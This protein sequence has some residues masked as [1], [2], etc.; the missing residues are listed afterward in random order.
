MAARRAKRRSAVAGASAR[1]EARR[2]LHDLQLHE[3]ELTVQNRQLR[4]ANHLLEESRDR[5]GK[6]YDHAPVAHLT[7]D[8]LGRVQAANLS[9]GRLLR[10]PAF[11][12]IGRHFRSL[13]P[14]DSRRT[15]DT[16]LASAFAGRKPAS[17]RVRL[18]GDGA[19]RVVELV[20][21]AASE[22]GGE[23]PLCHAAALDVT[24]R[25]EEAKRRAKLLRAAREARAR[26]EQA[27]AMKEQFLAVV[28]HELRTPLGPMLMWLEIL[29]GAG[30]A[31][32]PALRERAV[33]GIATCAHD[34]AALIDD[35]LDMARVAHGKFQINRGSVDFAAVVAGVI[36]RSSIAATA[37]QVTVLLESCP[38][39]CLISGDADRLRQVVGNLLSNAVK[40]SPVG[41]RVEVS[42]RTTAT[43]VGL[44]V[45]DG[46]EGISADLLP[47]LFEP[48]RQRESRRVRRHGGLGL[49]LSIVRAIVASHGGEISAE[50]QGPGLG[51]IFTILLPRSAGRP[52]LD[53]P[54]TLAL[55]SPLPEAARLVL[56]GV[57]VLVVD[58]HAPTREAVAASLER[59]GAQVVV[60]SSAELG[61]VA[62]SGPAPDVLISDLAMPEEDGYTFI[63][64]LRATRT[65]GRS[66]PRLAAL[67]LTAETGAKEL[68][69]AIDAGF[70]RYMRKPADPR[71]LVEA[72]AQLASAGP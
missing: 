30:P 32:D 2:L 38:E 44:T 37:R 14:V 61:R 57:R 29:Q 4:E 13:L 3:L 12:L 6:L 27:G 42:L 65:R 72:V 53:G 8:P 15:F 47:H 49:G 10:T 1:G 52:S 28:S 59:Q 11:Q 56:D 35:L 9:A 18:P 34:Q 40:F 23:L 48:F 71:Q 36:E 7:F 43:T 62:L 17:G 58:D 51:S 20:L 21:A 39:R 33:R 50:S 69:R 67:A 22:L 68:Q 70:D 26:A 66:S 25:V 24:A 19:E 55:P 41:G 63:R 45:R 31:L 46:G 64:E 60:A 54:E 5:Y 16:L